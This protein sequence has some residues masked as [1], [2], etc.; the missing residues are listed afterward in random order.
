MKY[1][2]GQNYSS[3]FLKS[4]QEHTHQ[5][6]CTVL[7]FQYT[8]T[9]KDTLGAVSSGYLT[10]STLLEA[11]HLHPDNIFLVVRSED[12][13]LTDTLKFDIHLDI[14]PDELTKGGEFHCLVLGS[15]RTDEIN[16]WE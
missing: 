4:L 7:D 9:G 8:P 13:Y 1:I 11:R 2:H 14:Y 5:I 10:L 16:T 15:Y 6:L 12:S 3:K